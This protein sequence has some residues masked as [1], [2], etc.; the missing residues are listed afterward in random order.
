MKNI[1]ILF[2]CILFSNVTM[3]S[4]WKKISSSASITGF[5]TENKVSGSKVILSD[6]TTG[7][8]LM[9]VSL[10]SVSS[11][12]PSGRGTGNA[13]MYVN[14]NLVAMNFVCTSPGKAMY[15]G[16]NKKGK[17][18]IFLEFINKSEVCYAFKKGIKGL[19]F[20]AMG[21]DAAS[22]KLS[23]ILVERGNAL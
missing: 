6:I 12:C 21:F 5:F 10:F 17:D 16:K 13:Y 8:E 2:I 18:Y 7:N 22:R 15:I 11:N 9:A 4:D 19:C 1:L 23:D 14:H 20:S 3:A